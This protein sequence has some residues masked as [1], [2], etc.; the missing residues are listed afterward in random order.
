M[1]VDQRKCPNLI[2]RLDS[3][4][5]SSNQATSAH[6][7]TPNMVRVEGM[8]VFR[9]LV[10]MGHLSSYESIACLF[11]PQLTPYTCKLDLELFRHLAIPGTDHPST[12]C[13]DII[14]HY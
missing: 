12:I 11:L 13:S 6:I 5:T 10:T 2:D 14:A 7:A 4:G 8:Q 3:I 1:V 9:Q